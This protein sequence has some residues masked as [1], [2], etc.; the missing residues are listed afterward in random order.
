MVEDILQI[1]FPENDEK[2]WQKRSDGD[3]ASILD[4]FTCWL[5][6][7]V[8]K[9]R[10]LESGLTKIFTVSSFLNTLAMTI[11]LFFKMFKI[12]CGF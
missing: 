11:I 6:K 8:L 3:L 12:W 5:S 1:N 9:E 7:R 2:T 4:A 10:F